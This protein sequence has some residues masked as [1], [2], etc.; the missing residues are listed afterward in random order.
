MNKCTP[1][2]QINLIM[3]LQKIS[4]IQKTSHMISFRSNAL[5]I[6]VS[7]L[8]YDLICDSSNFET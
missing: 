7:Y 6:N 4:I 1:H 3:S 2:P 5:C 8:Y